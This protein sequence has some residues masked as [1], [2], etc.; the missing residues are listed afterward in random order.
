MGI[1]TMV[2]GVFGIVKELLGFFWRKK[3]W[4]LIPFIVVLLVFG[5]LFMIASTT[6][7]GPFIYALF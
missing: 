7:L 5:V 6:G 3:M 1:L 2:K 4:W